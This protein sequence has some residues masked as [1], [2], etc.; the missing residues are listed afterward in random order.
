MRA[1]RLALISVPVVLHSW[2]L[3][4]VHYTPTLRGEPQAVP[5]SWCRF[6]AEGVQFRWL[7]VVKS[8]PSL[9]IALLRSPIFPYLLLAIAAAAI[10]VIWRFPLGRTRTPA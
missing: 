4:M 9:D 6:L 1:S 3:S 7:S 8:T 5:E 10:F 2:V